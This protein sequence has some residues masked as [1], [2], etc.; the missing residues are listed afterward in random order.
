[1]TRIKAR[2]RG[3]TLR[4]L[5]YHAIAD[6]QDDPVLSRYAVPERLFREH[7]DILE[8]ARYRLVGIDDVVGF[9]LGQQGLPKRALLL[10]FDDATR[11]FKDAAYPLLHE[12]GIPCVLFVPSGL[13]GETNRWDQARGSQTLELLSADEIRELSDGGVVIG[14]HG[15][16]HCP[17]TET[18]EDELQKEI[19]G[20]IEELEREG[21]G[22][23]RYFAYPHGRHDERV[24][25][26]ASRAGVAVG[27]TTKPALIHPG[28]NPL[29]LPRFVV[30]RSWVGWRFRLRVALAGRKIPGYARFRRFQRRYDR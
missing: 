26:A 20:S 24:L 14:A 3:R 17:L 8:R 7:I 15:R 27:F 11:D 30:Q 22:R 16:T 21:I 9:V 28:D 5:C 10:T 12:R 2:S 29:R 25:R 19:E 4:V 1:M 23:V 13:M 6:L 18:G